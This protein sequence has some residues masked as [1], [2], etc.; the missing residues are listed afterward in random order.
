MDEIINNIVKKLNLSTHDQDLDKNKN[1]AIIC[2][3][4]HPDYTFKS[5]SLINI[6]KKKKF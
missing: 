4:V 1:Y 3:R 6:A 2:D 5:L